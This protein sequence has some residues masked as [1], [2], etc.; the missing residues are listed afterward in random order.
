[1]KELLRQSMNPM[2]LGQTIN[3]VSMNG[4]IVLTQKILQ[5]NTVIDVSTVPAGNYIVTVGSSSHR[6]E[7]VK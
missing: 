6:I 1:M 2:Y 3:L 7:I 4:S 5:Q